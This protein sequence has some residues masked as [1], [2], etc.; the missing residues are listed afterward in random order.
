VTS[1]ATGG[2]SGWPPHPCRRLRSPSRS[3]G[4]VIAF[5]RHALDD[6]LDQLLSCD[7]IVLIAV[8]GSP[9]SR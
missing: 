5:V 7:R 8:G 9:S 6:L 3:G 4:A 2:W 1:K